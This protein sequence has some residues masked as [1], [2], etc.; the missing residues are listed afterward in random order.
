MAR[1]AYYTDVS[2][3]DFGEL[4]SLPPVP[5]ARRTSTR[6]GVTGRALHASSG[7]SSWKS[8][9]SPV[10]GRC[11]SNEGLAEVMIA[12]LSDDELSAVP[13][14]LDPKA[15]AEAQRARVVVAV[16]GLVQLA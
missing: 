13:L 1:K 15:V 4:E 7:G 2:E 11:L 12:P 3:A 6:P 14:C 10:W 8:T 9:N 5:A 16:Q